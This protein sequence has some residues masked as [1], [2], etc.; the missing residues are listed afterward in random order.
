MGL[1]EDIKTYEPF[2]EQEVC[3]QRM[4]LSFLE[5]NCQDYLLRSNETAHITVS[6]WTVNEKRDKVL[7]IYHNIYDSWSWVGGHADGIENLKEVAERELREETGV[8]HIKLL[9]ENIFSLESLTVDG[10]E[11]RGVYVPSHLHLN[12]TYLFEACE[13]DTLAMKPDENSGVRW[14]SLK[15]AVTLPNEPWMVQR[16]YQKLLNRMQTAPW[17]EL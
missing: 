5:K 4:M 12:I 10:H 8:E 3:D 17:N 14:C 11:K 2:N 9:S 6:A 1:Y 7:M 13:M 15:E 16:I